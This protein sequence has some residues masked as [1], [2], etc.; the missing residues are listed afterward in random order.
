[1]HF[2]QNFVVLMRRFLDLPKLKNAR[3]SVVCVKDCFH[4]IHS[5]LFSF[6]PGSK[7][8]RSRT[9]CRKR[10]RCSGLI[11]CQ[12]SAKRSAIRSVIRSTTRPRSTRCPPP[13][14]PNP[15]KRIRQRANRASAC[16]K[17]SSGKP[18]SGGASQF[19]S[20]FTTSPPMKMN[21]AKPTS[22]SGIKRFLI[23]SSS[24]F[25]Q[26]VVDALQSPSQALY[27]ISF[28]GQQRVDTHAGLTRDRSET[29]A[30]QL[31]RDKNITLFLWQFVDRQLQF[32]EQ[33][34]PH[35]L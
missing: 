3:W 7:P 35:V 1:M 16:Q 31:V 6:A 18:K 4:R 5:A 12:R 25:R 17:L 22:T 11:V 26:L 21:T 10:S 24:R 30:F 23:V 9:R 2:D 34:F 27:G 20:H 8:E 13:C 33:R 32:V 19:H 28:S 29:A 15:P 14:I